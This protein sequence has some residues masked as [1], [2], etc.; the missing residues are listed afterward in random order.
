MK[1]LILVLLIPHLLI[2]QYSPPMEF[3]KVQSGPFVGLQK[4]RHIV[5]ELGY[6]KRIKEVKLFRPHAQAFNVGVNYDFRAG[7]LGAD[8]GY[9]FRPS[10]I[11]LTMGVQAATRT[12]FEKSTVGISPTI[13]YKIWFLHANVGYY[14][15][16]KPIPGIKTNTLFV[17]LRMVFTEKSNLRKTP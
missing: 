17:Q 11:S 10:R 8:A 14:L 15:Y 16:P 1:Y 2:S 6:E 13:G 12:N 7:L 5:L 4:G 3:K 9:W